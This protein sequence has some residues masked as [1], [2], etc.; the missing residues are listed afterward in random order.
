MAKRRRKIS[1]RR[2]KRKWNDQPGPMMT[3]GNINYDIAGHRQ[4][5]CNGGIGNIHQLALRTG[6]IDDIDKSIN[7]HR[8]NATNGRTA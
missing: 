8:S 1:K 2:T 3:G 4:A 6:L 5:I 7:L